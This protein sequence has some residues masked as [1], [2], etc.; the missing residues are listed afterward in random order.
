TSSESAALPAYSS[1]PEAVAADMQSLAIGDPQET[2]SVPMIHSTVQM[3][4][5]DLFVPFGKQRP[6]TQTVLVRK[7]KRELYLRK[8]ANDADG[9]YVGTEAP[10]VDAGLVFVPGKNTSEDMLRQVHKVAFGME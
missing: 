1:L 3:R 10:A 9:N 6:V 5:R 4:K 7:M 2:I 8:Y